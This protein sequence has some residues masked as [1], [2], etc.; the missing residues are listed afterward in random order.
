MASAALS[1]PEKQAGWSAEQRQGGA[2]GVPMTVSAVRAKRRI[3]SDEHK[4]A[5]L[6]REEE[7]ERRRIEEVR[8]LVWRV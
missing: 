3:A 5:L 4:K 6:M 2:A 1:A 8:A 7:K